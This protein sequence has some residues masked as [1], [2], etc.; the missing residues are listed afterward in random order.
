MKKL[1][2]ITIALC[3]VLSAFSMNNVSMTT[4]EA[5]GSKYEYISLHER[6]AT[7]KEI[8]EKEI[9]NGDYY[10]RTRNSKI[11]VKKG[12][13]GKYKT[14]P[15]KVNIYSG[16][17]V[18]GGDVIFIETVNGVSSL[19][20]YTF[21][22]GKVKN[23]RKLPLSNNRCVGEESYEHSHIT[24][25]CG[26][27]IFFCSYNGL[28]DHEGSVMYSYNLKN[29]KI[30]KAG[31]NGQAEENTIGNYLIASERWRTDA[32][33]LPFDLYKFTSTG[34]VKKIKKISKS[35]YDV[36][37]YNGSLYWVD[38]TM[39]H[40][41]NPK[42]GKKAVLYTMKLDGSGKKKLFTETSRFAIFSVVSVNEKGIKLS[43]YNDMGSADYSYNFETKKMSTIKTK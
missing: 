29:K 2:V 11:Q 15:V 20:M 17:A 24:G 26:N 35:T 30:K 36:K 9:K 4:V 37:E 31:L 18:N 22:N 23:L 42:T 7:K 41:T 27:Y 33:T 40:A 38:T 5:A 13:T 19:K 34:T 12:K 10:F 3:I 14:I 39:Q 32:R 21:A 8:L 28:L 43:A 25:V 6:F 16:F 1:V